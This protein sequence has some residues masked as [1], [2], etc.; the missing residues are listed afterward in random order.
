M[1]YLPQV[2]SLVWHSCDHVDADEPVERGHDVGPYLQYK[3]NVVPSIRK[4]AL[5][6]KGDADIV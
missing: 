2:H 5:L 4:E 1:K 3:L 6:K